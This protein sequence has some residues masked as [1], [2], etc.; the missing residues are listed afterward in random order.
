MGLDLTLINAVTGKPFGITS[1]SI[2]AVYCNSK[3]RSKWNTISEPESQN[4]N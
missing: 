3:E 1:S 4:T 2:K